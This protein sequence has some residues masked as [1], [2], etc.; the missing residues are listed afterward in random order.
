MKAIVLAAGMGKRLLPLTQDKPKALVSVL[1][2][3]IIEHTLDA[4]VRKQV[5]E[6]IIVV[7]YCHE[8]IVAHFG[9]EHHGVPIRY[10][11]NA[12]YATTN[13]IYSLQL[14]LEHVE[15]DLILCE[16]DIVFRPEMLDAIDEQRGSNLV[17]VGRYEHYMSGTVVVFDPQ[18]Q[19]VSELLTKESQ[20]CY[21]P[22]ERLYKTV[23]VYYLSYRFLKQ[24]FIPTLEHYLSARTMNSYYELILGVLLYMGSEELRSQV[25]DNDHWFEID[26]ENDLEL[27]EY[28]FAAD[29][30]ELIR[31]LHGGYWRF[32]LIDFC[33][34]FNPYFPPQG[35]FDALAAR[36]PVL[37]TNYPSG[38]TKLLQLLSRWYKEDGFNPEN[39][40]LANGASEIIRALNKD[41]VTRVTIPVPT[42]NEYENR[43]PVERIN[44][45]TLPAAAGFVPDV[46]AL[47]RSVRD[48]GSNT[49]ILINPNNPTGAILPRAE[50][51]RLLEALPDVTVVVDESFIDFAGDRAA[52]SVQDLVPRYPQ[53]ALL[54]SI[55]KEFGVPGLRLGYMLTSN[56]ALK[57][58]IEERLPIWN[59]NS[60][61][62]YFVETFVDYKEQYERSMRQVAED[63]AVL[64]AG[65]QRIGYLE[66]LPSHANFIL[67][68][69]IGR[70]AQGLARALFNEHKILVKDCGNKRPLQQDD[71]VRVAVKSQAD[72]ARLLAAL[73]ALA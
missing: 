5:T 64:L 10:V 65:L 26:D 16:G 23:N 60:A 58:A 2:K 12:D 41:L 11:L 54:R 61:A 31:K 47:V 67:C 21:H 48:S 52:Y 66:P 46:D 25:V 53:L 55:S 14:G 62:E 37:L 22:R 56:Q 36:L 43:L 3:P 38:Q 27:A 9:H 40:I 42:F 33:Y 49:L 73:E 20:K 18:T 17:F 68:H 44:D 45:F 30:Y 71:Y 69:V 57:R 51:V 39:L 24:H 59:I 28:L 63:R 70:S 72:N 8:T 50:V 34:L 7:G 32:D 35:F 6:I 1:G 13:N 15:D 4:L 19:I 29:R